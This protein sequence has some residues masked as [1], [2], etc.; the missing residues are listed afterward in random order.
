MMLKNLFNTKNLSQVSKENDEL[1]VVLRLMFEIAISDGA[2]DKAE[3]EII[4]KKAEELNTE[5]KT[6]S[7]IIK[8]IID[9]SEK[10]TS[11]YSTVKKINEDYTKNEKLELLTS[12]WALVTADKQIDPYEE[13][14]YFKI[15]DLIKIKRSLAN[16]IKQKNIKAY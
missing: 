13:N 5:E 11:I 2:L 14:L 8:R 7:S 3:L 1:D 10:S 16:Q 4:R 15:A 9:D 6:N 12:L